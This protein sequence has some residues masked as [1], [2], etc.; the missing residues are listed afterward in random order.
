MTRLKDAEISSLESVEQTSIRLL[1][2][3]ER[4]DRIVRDQ[5][6]SMKRAGSSRRAED[7]QIE[8]NRRTIEILEEEIRTVKRQLTETLALFNERR[9]NVATPSRSRLGPLQSRVVGNI[10]SPRMKIGEL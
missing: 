2:M 5:R 4:L 8:T 7:R 6:E 9:Q 3:E 10:Q 1:S